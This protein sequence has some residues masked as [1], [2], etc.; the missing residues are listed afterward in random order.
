MYT[1]TY[2]ADNRSGVISENGVEVI[3]LT[4]S[5]E[6]VAGFTRWL[7][8]VSPSQP[9]EEQLSL[10]FMRFLKSNPQVGA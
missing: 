9:G 1:Y 8:C 3:T 6:Q 4:G 7:N 10:W 5:Q 2:Q